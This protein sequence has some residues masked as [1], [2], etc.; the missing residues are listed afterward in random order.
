M[1]LAEQEKLHADSIAFFADQATTAHAVA[2]G[3]VLEGKDDEARAWFLQSVQL[4][5]R[6]R[7]E[8]A[9]QFSPRRHT[10]P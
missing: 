10:N 4:T 2:C 6:E 5:L 3:C 1:T 8:K 9:R 7:A